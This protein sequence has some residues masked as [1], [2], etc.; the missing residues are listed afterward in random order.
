MRRSY[1]LA[2]L[3]LAL[4]TA[5]ASSQIRSSKHGGRHKLDKLFQRADKNGDGQISRYEWR[6]RHQAFDRID[7]N[8]DGF[9]SRDEARGA[10][11]HRAERLRRGAERLIQRLDKNGNGQISRDEWPGN[12]AGFERL[13]KNHDG[14]ISL[15]E[16]P[17]GRHRRQAP[18]DSNATTPV[19]PP[20]V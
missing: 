1:I 6:K 10:V 5:T 13:D 18:A 8:H 7:Q 16:L 14:F 19:K 9:I 15:D 4:T 12:P 20:Q 3:I 2:A 11:R 17:R